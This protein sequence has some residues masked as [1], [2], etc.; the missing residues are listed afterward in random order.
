MNN[1]LDVL[2]TFGR[3]CRCKFNMGLGKSMV[4]VRTD[5]DVKT[6]SGKFFLQNES[7][8]VGRSQVYLGIV[9]SLTQTC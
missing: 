7:L 3:E 6:Y 1:L 9:A 2:S 8:N 4:I 5:D